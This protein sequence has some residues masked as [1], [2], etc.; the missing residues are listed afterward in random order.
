M[1]LYRKIIVE[2]DSIVILRKQFIWEQRFKFGIDLCSVRYI[3][4]RYSSLK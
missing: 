3:D 2:I 1:R 4:I